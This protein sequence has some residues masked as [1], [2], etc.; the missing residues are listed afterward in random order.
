MTSKAAQLKALR[1]ELRYWQNYARIEAKGL[2][3]TRAKCQAIGAQMRA[4]VHPAET[5][6]PPERHPQPFTGEYAQAELL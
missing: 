6:P 3:A 4:L 2:Q 1:E 5:R